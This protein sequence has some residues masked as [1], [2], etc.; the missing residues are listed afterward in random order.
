MTVRLLI[1]T[2]TW[3]KNRSISLWAC[4]DLQRFQECR[5]RSDLCILPKYSLTT[6]FFIAGSVASDLSIVQENHYFD[7]EIEAR[8]TWILKTLKLCDGNGGLAMLPGGCCVRTGPPEEIPEHL[9]HS[10]RVQTPVIQCPNAQSPDNRL[11]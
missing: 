1:W 11:L 5:N 10:P 9:V 2:A 3:P 7:R 4:F 8:T 6:M